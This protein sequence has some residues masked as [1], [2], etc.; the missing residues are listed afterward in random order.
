M[1]KKVMA[2]IIVMIAVISIS[3][4][5]F[6]ASASNIKP[7]VDITKYQVITPE[8]S[9]SASDKKVV[10][11]SGKAPE[12]TKIIIDVYG[13]I[14]LTGNN[15]S[16]EKL[17]GKDDYILISSKTTKSGALGFGEE[18]ELILGVNKITVTFDVNGVPSVEKILYYYEKEQLEKS[19]RNS[20]IGSSTK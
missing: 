7:K 14:D 15:Y 19:P 11:I 6:A 10:L 2:S 18:V 17:P 20:F 1:W 9:S 13:A 3:T 4:V 5:G 8:K 16:L 12:G